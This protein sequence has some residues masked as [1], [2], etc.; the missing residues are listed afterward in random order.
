LCFQLVVEESVVIS[1]LNSP[2]STEKTVS[3][4]VIQSLKTVE[5]N[6]RNNEKVE[7]DNLNN[8]NELLELIKSEKNAQ[9]RDILRQVS[10]YLKETHFIDEAIVLVKNKQNLKVS[11]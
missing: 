2:K 4:S 11:L 3:P 8:T 1:N 7:L 6:N 10:E 9:T 5:E